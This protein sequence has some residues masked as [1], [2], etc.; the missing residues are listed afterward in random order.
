MTP[1]SACS[2]I[3]TLT[4]LALAALGYRLLEAIDAD[5]GENDRDAWIVHHRLGD[6]L[7]EALAHRRAHL[8][9]TS[10]TTTCGPPCLAL[11]QRRLDRVVV[12]ARHRRGRPALDSEALGDPAGPAVGGRPVVDHDGDQ[13]IESEARRQRDRLVVRA[14]VELGVTEEAHDPRGVIALQP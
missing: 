13:T 1:I 2:R 11:V 10:A 9:S 5:V 6:D 3:P 14:L 8:T 7:D 4:S 12:A